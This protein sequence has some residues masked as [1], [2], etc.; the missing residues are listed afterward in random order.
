M[1]EISR[2]KSL[3]RNRVEANIEDAVVKMATDHPA[4]GQIR[5]FNELIK[6]GLFSSSGGVRSVWLRQDRETFKKRLKALETLIA[7]NG[8]ILTDNQVTA[9]N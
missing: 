3:L 6:K 2:N 5:V 4:L 1:Q 7:Q 9:L 8:I